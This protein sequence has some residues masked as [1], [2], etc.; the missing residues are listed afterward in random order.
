M[1]RVAL[2][3]SA[4]TRMARM[5][6][7]RKAAKTAPILY[8]RADWKL[9]IE[10]QTLPQK[11]GCEPDQMGR[12]IIKELV[13]NALDCGASAVELSGAEQCCTVSDNGPGIAARDLL[14]VFAVN[15]PLRSSKL[16]R[17]PTRG[18]LGNGLRVVMGAVAAFDG[19][20]TVTT[21][22]HAYQLASCEC[23]EGCS[24]GAGLGNCWL[25]TIGNPD[26]SPE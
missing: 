9:F 13:D 21:R 14:L 10:P 8:E 5:R 20:I 6:A 18:M 12:V 23:Y 25:P 24:S 19:A 4:A 3:T 15:R 26:R 7:R 1:W 22:G 2:P 16:V 17:L 11:A